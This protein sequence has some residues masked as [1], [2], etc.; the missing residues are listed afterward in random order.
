MSLAFIFASIIGIFIFL[1]FIKK[2][3]PF[4]ICVIC[5][6]VS[7]AW[8]V[9]LGLYYLA[10]FNDPVILSLLMGGS[11]VG[12]YYMIEKRVSKS[13]T[14]FRLPFLLTLFFAAYSAVTLTFAVLPFLLITLTWI[15]LFSIYFYRNKPA[16]RQTVKN[17]TECCG[18]W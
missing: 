15:V 8:L 6:S 10:R 1:L 7:G 5:L 18:K 16:V 13:L 12:F 2:W 14:V 9:L 17:I 4:T 3:L 11:V